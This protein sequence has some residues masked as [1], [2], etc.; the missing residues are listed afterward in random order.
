MEDRKHSNP[1]LA[2]LTIFIV[3]AR[4]SFRVSF[5]LPSCI[6]IY[7]I[8]GYVDKRIIKPYIASAMLLFP[9]CSR[10]Y[11]TDCINQC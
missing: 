6:Y 5:S 10:V 8:L 1:V 4:A 9:S 11:F 2:A 3:N 7:C